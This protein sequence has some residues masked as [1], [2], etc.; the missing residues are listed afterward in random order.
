[1][2]KPRSCMIIILSSPKFFFTQK[3]VSILKLN[4][5]VFQGYLTWVLCKKF[6]INVF[7]NREIGLN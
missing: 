2:K 7:Q 4:S 1:M 6:I 5:P 3:L